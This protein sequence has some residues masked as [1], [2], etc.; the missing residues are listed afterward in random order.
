MGRIGVSYQ[1][2]SNTISELQ[3]QNISPSVDNIRSALGTG[4]K[5]T[6]TK[7]LKEWRQS[8]E[9]NS[10]SSAANHLPEDLLSLVKGLWHGMEEKQDKQ[11]L[12]IQN[13]YSEKEKI[14]NE[15]LSSLSNENNSL[16][17]KLHKSEE[18]L[19]AAEVNNQEQQKTI[20]KSE[21]DQMQI[22]L[23]NNSLK[24]RLIESQA[25]TEKMHSHLQK[26]QDNIEH[27]QQAESKLKEKQSL[28]LAELTNGF[29][30]K[31]KALEKEIFEN[32]NLQQKQQTNI[33]N[34]KDTLAQ[35][36]NVIKEVNVELGDLKTLKTQ[37]DILDKA[38]QGALLSLE[39]ADKQSV[40]SQLE[41][42]KQALL[43]E[44]SIDTNAKLQ[45]KITKQED[46]ITSLRDEN[47]FI[48]NEKANLTG[49]LSQIQH[50]GSLEFAK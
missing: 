43:L 20:N 48:A 15:K 41:N 5:T 40:T 26:L 19:N 36:E 39:R 24:V 25:E 47:N 6:I 8:N 16:K 14:I 31:V 2:I 49:Q 23:H 29:E 38:H 9:I 10:A 42:Q 44:Q 7:Y 32:I 33:S 28:R 11:I 17:E 34:L 27:Y 13:D 46:K 30:G 37:Y 12:D 1:D 50:A 18:A 3:G 35:K 45:T 21:I 4:S 22:N